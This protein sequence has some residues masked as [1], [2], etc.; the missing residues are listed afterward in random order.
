V[1]FYL[2]FLKIKIVNGGKE[3]VSGLRRLQIR[4]A[5]VGF[6]R[7]NKKTKKNRLRSKMKYKSE[8]R[9]RQGLR[10]NTKVKNEPGKGLK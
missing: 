10:C 1:L 5:I 6:K 3:H 8:I 2:A 7:S 4:I 9:P